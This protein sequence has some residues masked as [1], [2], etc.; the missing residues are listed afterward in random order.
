MFAGLFQTKPILDTGSSEWILDTFAWAVEHFDI[1]VFKDD[2]RLILPTNE[3]YP[4]KVN[5]INEM[6]QSVFDKTLKYAGM[7]HWP[8]QLVQPQH[9]QPQS[10]PRLSFDDAMR[11]DNAKPVALAEQQQQV[12]FISYNPNQINQPQDLVAS[13]AQSLASILIAQKGSLPPGGEEF[14]P[15]AVDL[16]AC[17]MGF[18]VMLANTAYQFKGGC[19]SCYNPHANR[20]V[21]LPEQEMLYCLA[22]FSVLKSMPAKT[23][24]SQL[25][26]HLKTTFK[27]A[28]KE[29]FKSV[30][31][32]ANPALLAA[33]S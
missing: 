24:H 17:F 25:K 15:Q 13:Y 14:I 32:S 4:G 18:G 30:K 20:E 7:E 31:Q 26:P 3:F 9:Y 11:G 12:I 29:L 16:V 27:K 5:S 6:A 1:N 33:A 19:G 23:V 22:L 28:Y 10:L 2:T 21:A 8:I